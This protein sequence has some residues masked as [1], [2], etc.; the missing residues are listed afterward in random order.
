M[1]LHDV[2]NQIDVTLPNFH[3]EHLYFIWRHKPLSHIIPI[4]L[5]FQSKNP[6]ISG[7]FPRHN[8][9]GNSHQ[10]FGGHIQNCLYTHSDHSD[11]V[12]CFYT[13]NERLLHPPIQLLNG[14]YFKLYPKRRRTFKPTYQYP[15][16]MKF[17]RSIRHEL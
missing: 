11:E 4:N 12:S 5:A 13:K 16:I 10:I 2:I 17:C 6:L 15:I 9:T 14:F 7:D 8:W 1:R 3:Q